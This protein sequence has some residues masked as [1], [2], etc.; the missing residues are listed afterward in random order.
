MPPGL[1]PQNN[2]RSRNYRE[3]GL[4]SSRT[5]CPLLGTSSP[6]TAH[7]CESDRRA[8]VQPSTYRTSQEYL[9][10]LLLQWHGRQC[11]KGD[12]EIDEIGRFFEASLHLH[13]PLIS[14]AYTF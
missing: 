3:C 4:Y 13:D 12:K 11:K 5:E 9:K 10:S 2:C 8:V 6:E 7:S 14:L 1:S